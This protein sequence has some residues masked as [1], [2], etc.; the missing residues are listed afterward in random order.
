MGSTA[1]IY[2]DILP[3]RDIPMICQEHAII[4]FTANL[5]EAAAFRLRPVSEETILLRVENDGTSK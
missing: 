1:W 3:A 5:N 2:E 4:I